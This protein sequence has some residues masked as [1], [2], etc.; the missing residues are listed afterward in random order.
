MHVVLFL[1]NGSNLLPIFGFW[2]S[3]SNNF[4][5]FKI[6]NL[7][8]GTFKSAVFGYFSAKSCNLPLLL[9][10]GTQEHGTLFLHSEVSVCNLLVVLDC[11]IG[12]SFS[13]FINFCCSIL[14]SYCSLFELALAWNWHMLCFYGIKFLSLWPCG[15][16]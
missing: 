6:S 4:K 8:N 5:L 10:L 11:Q 13:D 2:R 3:K 9:Q 15:S 1:L 16:K 12:F 14:I 7:K